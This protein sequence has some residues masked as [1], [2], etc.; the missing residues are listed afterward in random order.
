NT[1]ADASPQRVSD[2]LAAIDA[3]FRD[4]PEETGLPPDRVLFTLDGFRYPQ[5]AADGKGT[6][7]DQMRQAFQAKGEALGYEGIDLDPAFFAGHGKTGERFE[8]PTD[9]HWNPAGHAVA[10][11]AVVGS[12]LLRGMT[13]TRFGALERPR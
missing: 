12:R 4:L 8:Y 11:Q 2:S 7:F 1:P 6:Y 13:R 9:G 5:A 3:F 10:Y